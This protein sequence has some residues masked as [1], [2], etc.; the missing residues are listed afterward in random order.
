LIQNAQAR[1]VSGNNGTAASALSTSSE[2]KTKIPTMQQMQAQLVAQALE[3][4]HGDVATAAGII[5]V[6][7]E[8][9]EAIRNGKAL[10]TAES[11]TGSIVNGH[12][13]AVTSQLARRRGSR[14]TCLT[15]YH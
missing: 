11:S 3:A 1:A 8:Q 14:S 2:D 7:V 13:Y 12:M 6:S 10:V 9:I 4:A 5:G 15:T